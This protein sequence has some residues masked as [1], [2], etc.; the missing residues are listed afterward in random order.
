MAITSFASHYDQLSATTA[1]SFIGR[2]F[3]FTAAQERKIA[4]DTAANEDLNK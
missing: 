1:V 2:T 4:T 3:S